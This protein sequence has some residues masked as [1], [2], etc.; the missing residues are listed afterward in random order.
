METELERDTPAGLEVMSH[1][2]ATCIYRNDSPLNLEKLEN[3][4]RDRYM[5]FKGHR[6]CHSQKSTGVACC[7]GFWDRH[8]DEFPS[9]QIAQR[10]GLVI[11]VDPDD[12]V[13][14]RS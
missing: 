6:I 12:Y 5:G 3:E 13:R 7:R 8:K 11:F 2:C 10:L 1:Q 4:A 9:G 14:D